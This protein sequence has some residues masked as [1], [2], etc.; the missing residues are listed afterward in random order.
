[1]LPQCPWLK[2]K[3]LISPVKAQMPL[4][5][6]FVHCTNVEVSIVLFLMNEN[7]V[8]L[9]LAAVIQ[10]QVAMPDAS[11]L[12]PLAP[13]EFFHPYWR[14]QEYQFFTGWQTASVLSAVFCEEVVF[15]RVLCTAAAEAV[16]TS[17]LG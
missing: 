12:A 17:D 9:S 16:Q 14:N 8:Q 4:P 15:L 5:A 3:S 7:P 13:L 6:A 11:S 10:A 2:Q 1:M